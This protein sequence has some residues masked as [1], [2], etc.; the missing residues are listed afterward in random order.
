MTRSAVQT[1]GGSEA[2]LGGGPS[3]SR[4]EL[5]LPSRSGSVDPPPNPYKSEKRFKPQKQNAYYPSPA[6]RVSSGEPGQ[7]RN[8]HDVDVR[9]PE[10]RS[11]ASRCAIIW[12]C[13]G[14]C[15]GEHRV[16]ALDGTGCWKLDAEL[17]VYC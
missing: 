12:M 3:V 14:F 11:V 16:F 5:P 6:L 1:H 17:A 4:R 2:T 15:S 13:L 7:R 9:V 10:R 8:N